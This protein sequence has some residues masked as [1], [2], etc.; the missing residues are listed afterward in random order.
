MPDEQPLGLRERKKLDTRKALSDAALQL[1]F[2]RGLENVVREDIAARAGVSVRTFNNYFSGKYDALAYRHLARIRSAVEILRS[3]PANEPL[4]ESL[5]A[6]LLQPLEDELAE[7][8]GYAPSPTE[9]SEVRKLLA[10]PET[11]ALLSK[12]IE[13]SLVAAIAERSG[14]DPELDLYPRL[15]AGA[16]AAAQQAAFE[17]YVRTAPPVPVTHLLRQALTAFAAGLPQPPA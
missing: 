6:A 9:L 5:T 14:A 4:W 10:A 17:V 16:V 2:E 8:P 11:R 13:D 12:G 3:R 7:S 1:M 15:V